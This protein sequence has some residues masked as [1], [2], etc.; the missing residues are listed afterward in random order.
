MFKLFY[1]LKHTPSNIILSRTDSIG[2][3]ILTLPMAK[4]LKEHFKNIDV[5][6]LGKEYTRDVVQ[7]CS[8]SSGFIELNDFLNNDISINGQRPEAIIHVKPETKIAVK[9]KQL[10]IK[11]RIGTTNRLYH[12]T[13]CNKLVAL[14]RKKSSL[15][16]AQLNLKLLAP[17]GIKKIF[18]YDEIIAAYSLNNLKPLQQEFASLID[19]HKYNII[20]HPKSRGNA[21]EWDLRNYINL[22]RMLNKERYKIFISGVEADKPFVKPLM[23]EVGKLITDIQGKIPLNQF[24]P[25]I[26]ACDGL[27]ACSTGPLHIAAAVGIDAFGIYPPIKPLHAGRWG[28]IG[29]KAQ[30]FTLH[31]DCNDCKKNQQPCTCIMS[32]SV[33]TILNAIEKQATIKFS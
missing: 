14:S 22:V 20:L 30:V 32:I 13:T 7:A 28:P 9:A 1:S 15:H 24:M 6:F 18:S 21:R 33:Q 26:A 19:A 8:Y 29:K 25:F 16:E 5:Y 2:D 12:W 23:D 4:I 17:L 3:M 10:N 27:V 11:F 31:K